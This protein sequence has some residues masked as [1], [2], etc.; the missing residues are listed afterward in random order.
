MITYSVDLSTLSSNGIFFSTL[1]NDK[2]EFIDDIMEQLAIDIE[3]GIYKRITAIY[4]ARDYLSTQKQLQHITV[5]YPPYK[6]N[7]PNSSYRS[8]YDH[9]P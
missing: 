3:S 7:T 1:P 4:N 8:P 9:R 5:I 6:N 2:W